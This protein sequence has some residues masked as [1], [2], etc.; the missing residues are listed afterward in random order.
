MIIVLDTN[1]LFAAFATR[2]LCADILR[3]A[4]DNCTIVGSK[5]LLAE[6]QKTFSKKLKL[7]SAKTAS[8]ITFLE[9]Q[10][11]IVEPVPVEVK[12]CR[13]P[14]DLHIL[15]VAQATNAKFIVTGDNDL[16][17]LKRYGK[18][19]IINPRQF[20]TYILTLS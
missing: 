1:V 11:L 15:G 3:F 2:G 4:I 18:T 5:K 20:W 16:L 12:R 7:P 6:C 9:E 14:E 17:V 13:D 19:K 10:L 8:L